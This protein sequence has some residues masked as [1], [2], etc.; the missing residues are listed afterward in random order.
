M[1]EVSFEEWLVDAARDFGGVVS[2]LS[3]EE[4]GLATIQHGVV[5]R[6]RDG[7]ELQVPIVLSRASRGGDEEVE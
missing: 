1:L 3:F 2:A 5:L 4:A 6:F 7:S